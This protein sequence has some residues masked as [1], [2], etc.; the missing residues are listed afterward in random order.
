MLSPMQYLCHVV[1]KLWLVPQKNNC[2]TRNFLKPRFA[3]F[4]L[5]N[6]LMIKLIQGQTLRENVVFTGERVKKIAER[7]GY[8]RVTIDS[9]LCVWRMHVNMADLRRATRSLRSTAPG[10]FRRRRGV[11]NMCSYKTHKS[12][13]GNAHLLFSTYLYVCAYKTSF[14]KNDLQL[15]GGPEPSKQIIQKVLF[16]I[17]RFHF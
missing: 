9:E 10:R 15:K 7:R 3:R 4:A 14:A 12:T 17:G 6:E 8:I 5:I 16:P 2:T 13:T 1:N 11:S